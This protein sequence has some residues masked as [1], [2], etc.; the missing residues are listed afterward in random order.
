MSPQRVCLPRTE[1]H[2]LRSR[3]VDR[4]FEIRVGHPVAGFRPLP[5]GPLT[6]L[7]VLDGDLYFGTALEMTRLM[8]QLYG[9]LP[10]VLVVGVGYG[11]EDVRRQGDLRTRDLTPWPDAS[12]EAMAGGV[13]GWEPTLPEG[14]RMAGADRFLTFLRDELRPWLTELVPEAGDTILFGSSLGGLF[15]CWTL[16]TAPDSFAGYL[17]VSPA[18]WWNDGGLF[19]VEEEAANARSE[20]ARVFLAAGALEEDPTMPWSQRFRLVSNTR[21]MGARLG[22]RSADG[23][24]TTVVLP[25]E[26]HTSVVAPALTRGLRALMRGSA[27]RSP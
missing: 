6:V 18:L 15:A 14:E 12:Y 16:L 5:S 11:G 4:D 3:A 23:A 7:V 1:R 19:E 26:T 25:D 20:A 24:V 10:P 8:Y 13:A 2:V 27:S 9:E 22:R 21:E 17:A